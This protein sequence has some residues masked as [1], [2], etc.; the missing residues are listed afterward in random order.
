[1]QSCL[2]TRSL[3]DSRTSA[4]Q[5]Q[6]GAGWTTQL[7]HRRRP[8]LE[9]WWLP[10]CEIPTLPNPATSRLSAL[11]RRGESCWSRWGQ[12]SCRQDRRIGMQSR[13][14]R[15]FQTILTT[16]TRLDFSPTTCPDGAGSHLL[17]SSLSLPF[18]VLPPAPSFS[19]LSSLD[20]LRGFD[21]Y[22]ILGLGGVIQA[23]L[24]PAFP[25]TAVAQCS[26]SSSGT[27]FGRG[28]TF[29]TSSL[30]CLCFFRESP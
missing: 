27:W 9:S 28:F 11:G 4:V 6:G 19:R 15:G 22:W 26:P 16:C 5:P 25:G 23:V 29:T 12:I 21:M 2:P 13:F 17:S 24:K 20:A 7:L 1:M 30:R 14:E 18:P 10:P 8:P 3:S